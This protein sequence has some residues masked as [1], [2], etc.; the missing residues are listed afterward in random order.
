MYPNDPDPPSELIHDYGLYLLDQQL[1]K[2][3]KTLSAIPQVPLST[4]R[5]WGQLTPNFILHEQ[6]NYDQDELAA[7]VQLALEKFNREQSAVYDAVMQS[8]DQNL[9]KT[10]FV[11]SAGGGG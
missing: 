1:M 3:G 6:L 10:F 7:Q 5:D 4:L 2:G 9:G 8:Y 11:H